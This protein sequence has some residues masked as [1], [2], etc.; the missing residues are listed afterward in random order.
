MQPKSCDL[1]R[2]CRRA[3]LKK[4]RACATRVGGTRYKL[5]GGKGSSGEK[6]LS[7]P[8]LLASARTLLRGG[9]RFHATGLRKPDLLERG[10]RVSKCSG[11][12]NRG[13]KG[14]RLRGVIMQMT[15]GTLGTTV[16]GLLRSS[17]RGRKKSDPRLFSCRRLRVR[18]I[19]K[20]LLNR[21][22]VKV[23]WKRQRV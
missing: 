5:K 13:K 22:N 2:V 8:D 20:R 3:L 19:A 15:S 23:K 17:D 16:K 10:A 18:T 1:G 14:A 12:A 11:T 7:W 9:E 4:A 6:R 21:H